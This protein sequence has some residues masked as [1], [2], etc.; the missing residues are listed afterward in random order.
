MTWALAALGLSLGVQAFADAGP[1]MPTHRIVSPDGSFAVT[2][3]CSEANIQVRRQGG[4]AVMVC[5]AFGLVFVASHGMVSPDPSDGGKP[6]SYE[7]YI[8]SAHND[9]PPEEVKEFVL[10]GHAAIKVTCPEREGVACAEFVNIELGKPLMVAAAEPQPGA[11][12]AQDRSRA[13]QLARQF[14]DS[15]EILAK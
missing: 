11:L 12:A 8:A 4:G 5:P 6:R 1:A 7:K 15:L 3:P 9:L 13:M 14:Y 2:F 10:A